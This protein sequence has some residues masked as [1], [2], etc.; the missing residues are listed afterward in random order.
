M[1]NKKVEKTVNSVESNVV[2]SK[3][4]LMSL[5]MKNFKGE[6]KN[7]SEIKKVKKEIAQLLTKLKNQE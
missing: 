2:A 3:K 5:R 6:L 1:M 4:K 7:T